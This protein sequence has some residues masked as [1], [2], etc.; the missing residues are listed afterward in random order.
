MLFCFLQNPGAKV[1]TFLQNRATLS[2]LFLFY[3]ESSILSLYIDI[4]DA[5]IHFLSAQ[6]KKTAKLRLQALRI[7]IY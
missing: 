4:D 1:N 5:T 2:K 6:A 7:R 3:A